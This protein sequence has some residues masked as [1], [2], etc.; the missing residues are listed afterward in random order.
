MNKKRIDTELVRRGLCKSRQKAQ[1]MI[2]AGEVYIDEV[3]IIKSSECISEN[4]NIIIRN[5]NDDFVGRGAYKLD[6]AIK[7][8][9]A[10]V[11]GK[12]CMDIGAATGGFTDVLLKNGA[13][14]VYAIDVGYGQFDWKLRNDKRV[15]LYERTNARYLNKEMFSDIPEI[16]V[17]DV[18]FISIKIIIP[19]LL[20]FLADDPTMYVLIKP[21]FE[22]GKEN[23]GKNGV[24]KD[25][26]VHIEVIKNIS[27]FLE[28]INLCITKLDYS[29]IKGPKGNIE[30]I[31]EIKKALLNDKTIDIDQVVYNAHNDLNNKN[32]Q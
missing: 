28:G 4:A 19:E 3:K 17:M 22:A 15:V 11:R 21:Q 8:F 2:M 9:N 23:V 14:K 30:Y 7:V 20:K 29:P 5:K 10:D 24:I 25:P 1:A 18:S 27:E 26:K 12:I 31:C 16:V 13:K 6:K 32:E